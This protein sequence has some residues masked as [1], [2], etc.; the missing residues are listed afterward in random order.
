MMKR[1]KVMKT[2]KSIFSIIVVLLCLVFCP[3]GFAAKTLTLYDDFND[4]TL[5]PAKWLVEPSENAGAVTVESGTLKI[6][7]E[8]EKGKYIQAFL[9][10]P[11]KT[12]D[13]LEAK[14]KLSS[15]T[16]VVQ[17]FGIS[18]CLWNDG[19]FD[20]SARISFHKSYPDD[21]L[22]INGDIRKTPGENNFYFVPIPKGYPPLEQLLSPGTLCGNASVDTWYRVRIAFDGKQVL[23]YLKEGE[24]ELKEEDIKAVYPVAGIVEPPVRPSLCLFGLSYAAEP[25]ILEG[26][27]DDIAV[28]KSSASYAIS[29]IIE[30]AT[31]N[32]TVGLYAGTFPLETRKVQPDGRYTFKFLSDGTTNTVRSPYPCCRLAPSEKTVFIQGADQ[33]DINFTVQ[34]DNDTK[35]SLY[36]IAGGRL[37]DGNGGEPLDDS[38]ILVRGSTI[39]SV[40]KAAGTPIPEGY[41]IIDAQGKAI[42]PGLADMHVHIAREATPKIF[43]G[44]VL[45]ENIGVEYQ[46]QLYAFL[47][48]G[49]TSILDMISDENLI[50]DLRKK[51]RQGCLV[52]P[53]I[54][55]A[56]LAIVKRSD[57]YEYAYTR[58]DPTPEGAKQVVELYAKNKPDVGKILFYSSSEEED[59]ALKYLID[60]LHSRGLKSVVH[61]PMNFQSKKIARV[62]PDA[63]AHMTLFPDDEVIKTIIKNKIAVITTLNL[64]YG[65]FILTVNPD[66]FDEPLVK[67]CV[68]PRLL[69]AYKD[70]A[71]LRAANNIFSLSYWAQLLWK[72]SVPDLFRK[73]RELNDAGIL[74]MTGTDAG[75]NGNFQG[76]AEH[77]EISHLVDAGFTPLQAI[78]MATQN[79]PFFLGKL[80]RQGT[81]EAGKLAD[82]VIL[83]AD[84]RKDISNTKKI[85]LVMKDGKIM[86][87]GMLSRDITDRLS[88]EARY[89]ADRIDLMPDA[90]FKDSAAANKTALTGM[91][92]EIYSTLKKADDNETSQQ[93]YAQASQMLSGTVM[94]LIDGC[95][96]GSSGDDLVTDCAYQKEVYAAAE[97]LVVDCLNKK[98]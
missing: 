85:A 60:E 88:E 29:G 21:P 82:L 33:T 98:E 86:D 40:S 91:M 53:R 15:A 17:R 46:K 75:T 22:T 51:E 83:K 67:S 44:Y 56:G 70:P 37:I 45:D 18:V 94:P 61:G 2:Q 73:T 14:I 92:E 89:I 16:E 12:F 59:H 41:Q 50:Y 78:T 57:R 25:S 49:V 7:G 90:A 6:S 71:L 11:N 68:D 36:A 38:L 28:G 26:F 23:F 79:G 32:T 48:C 30:G 58:F 64:S 34:A 43:P 4:N 35:V 84:P 93:N 1:I 19:I 62:T 69:S 55:S 8:F 80:D 10:G 81:I 5:D 63:L 66:L 39:Q 95:S 52:S 24:G 97:Q 96:N 20:Y 72:A 87:R 76:A 74:L 13:A 47:F 77:D 31:D 27:F 9:L 42:I 3:Q 54:Y 65:R